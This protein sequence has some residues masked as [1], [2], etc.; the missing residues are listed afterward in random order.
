[1]RA[2]RVE[3]DFGL[4]ARQDRETRESAGTKLFGLRERFWYGFAEGRVTNQKGGISGRVAGESAEFSFPGSAEG[5]ENAIAL[6]GTLNY[7]LD[8]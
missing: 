6:V 2:E 4:H 1:M 5:R 3:F 8:F 7:D